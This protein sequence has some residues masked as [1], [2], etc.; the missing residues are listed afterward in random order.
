MSLWD[1]H[2]CCISIG[3]AVM[4]S[5]ERGVT[6]DRFYGKAVQVFETRKAMR[7]MYRLNVR[8]TICVQSVY[9]SRK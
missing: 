7:P 3:S 2:I 1:G 4:C 9:I 6:R 5:R 8:R